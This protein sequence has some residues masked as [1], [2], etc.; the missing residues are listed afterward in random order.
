[1]IMDTIL[2]EL[3]LF[4]TIFGIDFLSS[5]DQFCLFKFYLDFSTVLINFEKTK[6]HINRG[7]NDMKQQDIFYII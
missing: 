3:P 7:K 1:M 6:E 5:E 2:K 4:L